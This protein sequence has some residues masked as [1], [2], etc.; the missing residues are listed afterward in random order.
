MSVGSPQISQ[1]EPL[2]KID[3]DFKP[4]TIT[5]RFFISDVW[6]GLEFASD[7]TTNY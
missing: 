1:P 5:A 4:L 6:Q 2:V 3:N 7:V